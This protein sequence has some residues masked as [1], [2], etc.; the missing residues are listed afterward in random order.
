MR[1]RLSPDAAR[2]LDKVLDVIADLDPLD[3]AMLGH[4]LLCVGLSYL[5]KDRQNGFV[6]GLETSVPNMLKE[7]ADAGPTGA[8]SYLDALIWEILQCRLKYQNP[9]AGRD[10]RALLR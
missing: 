3:V 5:P 10:F 4:A 7:F 6:D 8:G 2:R 9:N 1:H